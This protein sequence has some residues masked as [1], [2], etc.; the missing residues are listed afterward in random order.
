[1][2]IEEIGDKHNEITA[3]V[4]KM[5]LSDLANH[6]FDHAV[7][8]AE[9]TDS[10]IT[11]DGDYTETYWQMQTEASILSETANRLLEIERN[12]VDRSN[13]QK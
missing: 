13:I 10:H 12:G 4:A 3:K 9:Y 2:T 11:D 5:S 6:L 1:M 7:W 8:Y